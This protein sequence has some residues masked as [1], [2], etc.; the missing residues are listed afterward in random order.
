MEQHSSGL[1]PI[2]NTAES[3]SSPLLCVSMPAFTQTLF[4]EELKLL[5]GVCRI[6][7]RQLLLKASF[8]CSQLWPSALRLL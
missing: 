4:S 6:K 2:L 3:S 8:L 1:N 5:K 7:V